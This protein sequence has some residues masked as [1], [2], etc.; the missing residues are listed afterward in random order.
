MCLAFLQVPVQ[1]Q[2]RVQRQILPNQ[3]LVPKGAGGI[4]ASVQPAAT[5][6]ADCTA[7][8]IYMPGPDVEAVHRNL[9]RGPSGTWQPATS[10]SHEAASRTHPS[11][12]ASSSGVTSSSRVCGGVP[13]RA[14]SHSW[15]MRAERAE[16][17]RAEDRCAAGMPAAHRLATWSCIRAVEREKAWARRRGPKVTVG[18]GVGGLATCRAPG[19]K[20]RVGGE[21]GQGAGGRT[22]SVTTG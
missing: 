15:S 2:G 11:D 10:T 19:P 6:E 7:S 18:S 9:L 4:V 8:A 3:K 17:G 12:A 1:L 22:E 13:L 16:A 5:A 20:G 14:P 21:Q